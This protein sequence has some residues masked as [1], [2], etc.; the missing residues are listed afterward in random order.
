MASNQHLASKT[1]YYHQ[2]IDYFLPFLSLISVS[3][4]LLG[5]VFATYYLYFGFNFFNA[6]FF[7]SVLCIGIL[8]WYFTEVITRKI[9]KQSSK[10][11]N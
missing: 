11:A 3:G 8:A 9:E 7:L 4:I 1:N 2:K 6:I 10:D 5:L